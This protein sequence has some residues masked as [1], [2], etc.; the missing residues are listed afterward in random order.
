MAKL[1]EKENY[2]RLMRGEVP[3]W[4]PIYNFGAPDPEGHPVSQRKCF[5]GP[6]CQQMATLQPAKDIWG[7]T[8]VAVDGGKLPEPGNFILDDITRWRDVIKAPDVS[9]FDWEKVA[10][11][12]LEK[13][14]VDR[15]NTA[16]C[17]VLHTGYFQAIM[18][19]MGFSE[20]LCALA[21]EPDECMELV[22][23]MSD[24]YLNYAE[25][26]ID[27]IKPDIFAIT[28]DIATFRSPFISLSLYREIFEPFYRKQAKLATD[29]GIPID[30]HCCGQCQDFL[31][32]WLDFG[33]NAWQPA[34]V[35]NDLAAIKKKYGNRL[36]ICGGFDMT[37]ELADIDCPR[38][39]IEAA[40]K[41]TIDLLAPGGGYAFCGSFL[42][43]IG[44]E[45]TALKNKWLNDFVRE[46]GANYYK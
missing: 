4:I 42:G 29:R 13:W 38:E 21:E 28:D 44:D 14:N 26:V 36:A 6:L 17:F 9:D 34:Q 11:S 30:M 40:A 5:S 35:S 25:H 12:D 19:F 43:P 22:E 33:V 20:G 45:K 39:A 46:Y 8:Y 27:Y 16:L 31:D 10:R 7:V 3:E 1:T 32:D 41:E 24:F 18:S 15:E 23:Y 2:L 37:E